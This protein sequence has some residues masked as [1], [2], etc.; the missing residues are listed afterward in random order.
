M[1]PTLTITALYNYDNTLF[2]DMFLP[3]SI[4]KDVLVENLLGETFELEVLYPDAEIMKSMITKWSRTMITE[5]RRTEAALEAEYDIIGLSEKEIEKRNL[6][7]DSSGESRNISDHSVAGFNSN[8][9]DSLVQSSADTSNLN[10]LT[11]TNDT[12]EIER[13]RTLSGIINGKTP[14]EII[15][16]EVLFRS[17][18]DMYSIIIEQFKQRFCLMVY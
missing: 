18:Y 15:E 9:T 12:G 17:K 11:S 2:D 8:N 3:D 5:W 16:K 1:Q 7:I 4:F 14:S 6:S 10:S 13:E